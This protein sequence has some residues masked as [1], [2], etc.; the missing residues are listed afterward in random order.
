MLPI[1]LSL[2]KSFKVAGYWCIVLASFAFMSLAN[3]F[4]LAF[5][6]LISSLFFNCTPTI[7]L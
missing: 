3:I 6:I 2:Q 7:A 1:F 5:F 4:F